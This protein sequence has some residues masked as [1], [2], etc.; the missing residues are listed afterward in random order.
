MQYAAP[1]TIVHMPFRH[2]LFYSAQVET[3]VYRDFP[4]EEFASEMVL[5]NE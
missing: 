2:D 5:L 4:I 1:K 3:I